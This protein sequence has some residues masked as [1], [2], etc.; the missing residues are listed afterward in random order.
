MFLCA[1]PFAFIVL[2]NDK[3]V[4]L[5]RNGFVNRLTCN[6]ETRYKNLYRGSFNA[7]D[8]SVQ[9]SRQTQVQLRVQDTALE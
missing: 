8:H 9:N 2:S 5:R 7:K 6:Y 4:F 1:L 3:N